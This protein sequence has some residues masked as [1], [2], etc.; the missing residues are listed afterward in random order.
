MSHLSHLTRS[1]KA[2]LKT[3][4]T[5]Q[6]FCLCKDCESPHTHTFVYHYCMLCGLAG[7]GVHECGQDKVINDL[8]IASDNII[9]PEL[10]QCKYIGCKSWQTH[11][12]E[13]HICSVCFKSNHECQKH[14]ETSEKNILYTK[15]QLILSASRR[16]GRRNQA[17]TIYKNNVNGLVIVRRHKYGDRMRFFHFSDQMEVKKKKEKIKE[18]IHGCHVCR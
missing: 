4:N 17:Y 18:L 16:F 3:T 14:L 6:Q 11:T 9:I 12:S 5:T 7:H 13:G 2:K 10:N 1:K 15:K 8:I